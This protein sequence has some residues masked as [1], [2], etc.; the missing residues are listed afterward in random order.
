MLAFA[1]ACWTASQPAPP[2]ANVATEQRAAPVADGIPSTGNPAA[3]V[4]IVSY[5]NY[6]CSHCITFEPILEQLVGHYGDKLFVQYRTL[7]LSAWADSDLAATAALAAH[8]QGKFLEMH[9][10][11]FRGAG[12]YRTFDAETMSRYAASIGLDVTRFERDLDDPVLHARVAKDTADAEEAE[13]MYVPFLFI[14]GTPYEG[15]RDLASLTT[16]LDA[17]LR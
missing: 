12:T 4:K 7:R 14:N 17:L 13:V 6:R 1:S 8:R 16:H 5:Y 11:L 9:R 3:R 10:A 15:E 2:P